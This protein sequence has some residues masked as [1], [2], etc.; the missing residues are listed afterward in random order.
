MKHTNTILLAAACSAVLSLLPRSSE[1]CFAAP[2][3]PPRSPG[4]EDTEAERAK[5]GALDTRLTEKGR[6]AFPEAMRFMEEADVGSKY[7]ENA[8]TRIDQLDGLDILSPGDPRLLA[9]VRGT[10]RRVLGYHY[11]WETDAARRGLIYLAKKGDARDNYLFEKYLTNGNL[12]ESRKAW[13]NTHSE[14]G[15][16]II[17]PYRILQHRVAG[18]NIVAG[19]CDRK[20]YPHQE[21][22]DF[23]MHAY[24][25]ND[26]RFIPSVA[27][28]GPQAAYVY[29]ALRQACLAGQD[30]G[31]GSP[32]SAVTNTAPELLTMRVW[33]DA[34]GEA[35]CDVDLAK[36]GISVPGLRMADTNTPP[37]PLQQNAQPP[38][39]AAI[40]T[41]ATDIA[42]PAITPSPRSWLATLF[43]LG[44]GMVAALVLLIALWKKRQQ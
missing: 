7:L 35:V 40:E 22:F 29:E 27:N 32:Y 24:S 43:A 12:W 3:P 1:A 4:A 9:S 23:Q 33:F 11:W 2:P 15:L 41:N 44:T 20:A 19:V 8:F 42:D 5:W 38:P 14:E 34:D 31:D 21:A 37:P 30:P 6:D 13:Q 16:R 36:Y 25:T 17:M 18:T 10:L 26:L 39:V 28:T